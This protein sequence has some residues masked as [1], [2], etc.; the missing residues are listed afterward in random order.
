MKTYGAILTAVFL[1]G[2]PAFAQSHEAVR[3]QFHQGTSEENLKNIL[4]R[5]ADET[6][7]VILAYIGAAEAIMAEHAF[8]P[9]SKYNYFKKGVDKIES[10]IGW[11][12]N[13]ENVYLRLMIQ[14]NAPRFLN[15]H[16][17]IQGDLDYFSANFHVSAI[18]NRWKMKFLNA[19]LRFDQRGYDFSGLRKL[20][21]STDKNGIGSTS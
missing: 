4:K 14:L 11:Q 12:K 21:E 15:Y 6:D 7:P 18:N 20:K 5:Y 16:D 3:Q 13:L 10:S 8:L 19:I 1:I 17:D 2:L 9:L